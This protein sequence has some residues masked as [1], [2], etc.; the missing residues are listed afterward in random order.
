MTTTTQNTKAAQDCLQAAQDLISKI[1]KGEKI[2]DPFAGL[3]AD[4]N[5]SGTM[6]KPTFEMI[7]QQINNAK[8]YL[9]L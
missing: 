7:D 5:P 2:E 4:S 6:I 9:G 8:I 3:F 1:D